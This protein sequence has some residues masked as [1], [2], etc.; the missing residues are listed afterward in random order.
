MGERRRGFTLI[1]LLVVIA[2]IAVLAAMLAPVFVAARK[3][4]QGS[5]AGRSAKQLFTATSLYATDYDDTYPVAMFDNGNGYLQTW[6]GL[7]TAKTEFDRQRGMLS[8]YIKGFLQADPT[9]IAKPYLGDGTGFGYNYGY[10]G[11]DFSITQNYSTWP[12]CQNPASMTTLSYPSRTVIFATS[13]FFNAPW[14][15]GGDSQIYDFGFVD[16]PSGWNG[17]PNVDFRHFDKRT[18]DTV[19]KEVKTTGKAFCVFGDGH[20]QSRTQHQLDDSYFERAPN[21]MGLE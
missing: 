11:S 15:P 14:L 6:F 19:K 3:A 5:A 21:L 2:I 4:V 17:N 7:Q 10:I 8:P 18:V 13:A 9:H 20:V 1:E 16:A 12:N